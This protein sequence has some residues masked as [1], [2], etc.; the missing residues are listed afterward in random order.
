MQ[1]Y[2]LPY[3]GYWQ[4]IKH[5]DA[6]VVYDNIKYTK[7]GW[8]NRNRFLLNG[9]DCVFSLPL[10]RDSDFLDIN[11]RF[12]AD[13]YDGEELL[14]RFREAYRRAPHFDSTVPLLELILLSKERNL[15][16]YIRRSI[17][18]VCDHLDIKT[19]LLTSS[20]LACDHTLRSSERVKAICQHLGASEYINPP[21]G[22][23]LY[24]R[25]DFARS[26]ITLRFLKPSAFEYE[27]FNHQFVPWLSIVDILMFNPLEKI[28]VRLEHSYSLD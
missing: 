16:T 22:I 10:R 12:I 23:D 18:A 26:G 17:E 8:I 28:E 9:A 4:L 6:F 24:N 2:F 11:K 25:D 27:Q 3:I 13:S 14:N 15:F 21:G 20:S 1:P 7:K 5:V 19:P